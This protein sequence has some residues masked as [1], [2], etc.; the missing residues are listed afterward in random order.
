MKTLEKLAPTAIDK[1]KV[2]DVKPV[3][4]EPLPTPLQRLA[5]ELSDA[6]IGCYMTAEKSKA[7]QA[8]HDEFEAERSKL[9]KKYM[10]KEIL[11]VKEKSK[12]E[13]VILNKKNER[14]RPKTTD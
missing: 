1:K 9:V 8:I 10:K 4:K 5:N 7:I 13:L 2:I 14:K 12:E 3:E 6:Y 11:L